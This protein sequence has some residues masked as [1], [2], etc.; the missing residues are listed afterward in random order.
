MDNKKGGSNEKNGAIFV[1]MILVL[2]FVFVTDSFAQRGM[3]WREAAAGR[4][5]TVWQN[6]RY[7]DCGNTCQ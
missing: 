4:G 6:V 5:N 2:V 1:V 7:K 3:R